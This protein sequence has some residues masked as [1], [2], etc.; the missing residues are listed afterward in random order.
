ME[1]PFGMTIIGDK[2]YVGE[3]ENGLRIFD[4]SSVRSLSEIDRIRGISA[5]DVIPH[6]KFEEIL[7]IASSKGLTQFAINN[8]GDLSALSFIGF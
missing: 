7:L 8:D 2:L 4:A 5:Y 3:G 1:S 6:P